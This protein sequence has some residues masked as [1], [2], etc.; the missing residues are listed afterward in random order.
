MLK[1]TDKRS[2][3]AT[4]Y[5]RTAYAQGVPRPHS[6]QNMVRMEAKGKKVQQFVKA[7][8]TGI[9]L[10]HVVS[11][12]ERLPI[13]VPVLHDKGVKVTAQTPDPRGILVKGAVQVGISSARGLFLN[14]FC[15][16]FTNGYYRGVVKL[17]RWQVIPARS[18]SIK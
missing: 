1:E 16:G 11:P 9:D 10:I 12:G 6:T 18:R 15:F 7:P 8:A 3:K 5:P 17:M 2:Q 13:D 14:C 4:S